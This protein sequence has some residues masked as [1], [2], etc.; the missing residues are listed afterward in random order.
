MTQYKRANYISNHTEDFIS[1][2]Y[3]ELKKTPDKC[4]VLDIGCGKG[5]LDI[6]MAH[7]VKTITGI[8]IRLRRIQSAQKHSKHIKNAEFITMSIF[9]LNEIEK[10]DVII[11]SD[12]LEHVEK[13]KELLKKSLTLLRGD[14]IMFVSTPNRL[15]PIEAH[16]DLPFLGYLP[17][18]VADRY[19]KLFGR[20]G[21]VGMHPLSYRKFTKLLNSF[22]IDYVFKPWQNPKKVIHKL[23]KL[24]VGV[25]PLFWRFSNAFQ[26]IVTKGGK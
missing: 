21:Y 15:W 11:L 9:D 23:G 6:N 19:A 3:P 14:G 24:F 17:M 20:K 7:N 10:Y 26:V 4:D 2:W 25:S 12:V 1:L 13:Q 8:D 22:D 5:E 16:T 18:D